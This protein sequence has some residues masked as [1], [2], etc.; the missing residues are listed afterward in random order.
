MVS[1]PKLL[2]KD[3]EKLFPSVEEVF[4]KAIVDELI[5]LATTRIATLTPVMYI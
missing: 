4:F 1:T 2:L 3:R 5:T